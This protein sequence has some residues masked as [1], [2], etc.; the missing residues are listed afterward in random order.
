MDDAKA[1][2]RAGEGL[3][4]DP[5][6]RAAGDQALSCWTLPALRQEVHTLTRVGVPLMTVRTDWMFGF[7][8]REVRRCEWDTLLPKLGLLAQI[9]HVEATTVSWGFD[10][11]RG[12]PRPRPTDGSGRIAGRALVQGN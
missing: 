5:W 1:P 10:S 4:L 11:L 3:R 7:Q 8:R 2:S 12:A 9:S 6:R